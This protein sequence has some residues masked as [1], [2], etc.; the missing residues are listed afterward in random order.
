MLDAL[1]TDFAL[2]KDTRSSIHDRLRLLKTRQ[3]SDSK[4]VVNLFGHSQEQ[5]FAFQPAS[6]TLFHMQV[7]NEQSLQVSSVKIFISYKLITVF[8]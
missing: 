8:K 7:G 2:F 6:S 1:S 5:K 4:N 3:A